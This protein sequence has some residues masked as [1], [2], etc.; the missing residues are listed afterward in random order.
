MPSDTSVLFQN[1]HQVLQKLEEAEQALG[2]APRAI[3][4]GEKRVS[5][6]EQDIAD[7]KQKIRDL[8]KT[9]DDLNLE[10]K[11]REA[12]I[13]KL[14]IMVYPLAATSL[15]FGLYW[16]G[17][18]GLEPA[19]QLLPLSAFSTHVLVSILAYS[20]ITIAAIQSILYLYQEIQFKQRATPTMLA[21]LPPLQTM[22]VLLFRLVGIGFLLLSLTL[23]S[24]ALFSKEIFGRAFEFN[25]HTVLALL[26]WLVFAVL[27]Y[28]RRSSGLRGLPATA[29]TLL[30]FALIQLGY[31]GTKIVNE[32]LNL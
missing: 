21:S 15:L 1:L 29:W 19:R 27:L 10:L 13:Q 16:N 3:S 28:R 17:G 6:C 20:L 7:Q 8:Q 25:H 26:G 24:G 30:G 31:F 23:L 5:R 18:S 22:E 11:T 4:V 2:E 12:E 14:G 9:A 32:S